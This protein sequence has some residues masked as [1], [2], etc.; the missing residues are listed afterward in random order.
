MR[1]PAPDL[2]TAGWRS[3]AIVGGLLLVVFALV[4]IS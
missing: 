1:G 4:A 3:F 2:P